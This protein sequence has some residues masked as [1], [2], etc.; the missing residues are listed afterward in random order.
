MLD[1]SIDLNGW[2]EETRVT[3][4]VDGTVAVEVK[5]GLALEYFR[6]RVP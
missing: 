1:R 4:G 3:I 5:G 6:A 2:S